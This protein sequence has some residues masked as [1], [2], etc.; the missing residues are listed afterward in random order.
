MQPIDGIT[1]PFFFYNQTSCWGWATW[2]RAWRFYQPEAAILYHNILK[3]KRDREFNLENSYPFLQHLKNNIDGTWNTWAIKWHASVF[4]LKGLCLHPNI[5]YTQNIG[6]DGSGTHCSVDDTYTVT[7]LNTNKFSA[8]TTLKENKRILRK[9]I[10]FNKSTSAKEDK[11]LVYRLYRKI[12]N[13]LKW[14]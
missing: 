5:S 8:V 13:K 9:V 7:Q 10:K 1:P 14:S 6:M 11:G 3:T 12:K 4:L 2:K